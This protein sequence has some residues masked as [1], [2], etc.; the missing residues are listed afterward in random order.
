MKKHKW[1]EILIAIVLCIIF[2]PIILFILIIMFFQYVVPAPFEYKK[3]KKSKYFE[4][5]KKKY[6]IGITYDP[7]YLLQNDL[8]EYNIQ[9]EEIRKPYGYMCLINDYFCFALFEIDN[10][11]LVDEEVEVKVH[12]NSPYIKIEDFILDERKHFEN[13]CVNRKFNILIFKEDESE[14]SDIL[15]NELNKLSLQNKGIYFYSDTKDLTRIVKEIII[16]KIN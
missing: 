16:K 10:L 15:S 14:Y 9:L 4:T 6:K 5:Y 11:K 12:G 3:Y 13:E 2:S 8:L 1:Y 7:H